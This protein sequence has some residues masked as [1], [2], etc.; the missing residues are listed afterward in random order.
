MIHPHWASA[1]Y[2]RKG[3]SGYEEL[4]G[5]KSIWSDKQRDLRG[6]DELQIEQINYQSN[7]HEVFNSQEIKQ[8]QRR[9]KEENYGR[10]CIRAAEEPNW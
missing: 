6:N 3:G 5:V 9:I 4:E 10:R 8:P 2:A 7:F 1:L